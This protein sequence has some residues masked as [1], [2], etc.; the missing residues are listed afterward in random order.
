MERPISGAI[1]HD[2]AVVTYVCTDTS[3][4]Q[5]DSNILKRALKAVEHMATVGTHFIRK[6]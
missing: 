2:N 4:L 1:M 6:D 3:F 5:M